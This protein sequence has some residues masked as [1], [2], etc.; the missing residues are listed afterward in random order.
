MVGEAKNKDKEET[1]E[2][3]LTL[4]DEFEEYLKKDIPDSQPE[5]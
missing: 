4:E 1:K 2:D 3:D 5:D